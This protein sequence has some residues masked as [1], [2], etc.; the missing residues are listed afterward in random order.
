MSWR[1]LA[2]WLFPTQQPQGTPRAS[3]R[4]LKHQTMHHQKQAREKT[5]KGKNKAT[6]QFFSSISSSFKAMTAGLRAKPEPMVIAMCQ[7]ARSGDLGHL[8]GFVTQ[9]VNINGQNDEGYTPLIC[10]ANAA[11]NK[12]RT[13]LIEALQSEDQTLVQKL[14]TFGADVNKMGQ[15]N[16]L[17]LAR[18]L[19]NQELV[20]MLTERGAQAS[21]PSKVEIAPATP[22]SPN[23]PSTSSR[24]QAL[25]QSGS[26]EMPPPYTEA[27]AFDGL[28]TP[29]TSNSGMKL[30]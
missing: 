21:I 11:D 23:G 28:T 13:P 2:A 6:G 19:Q 25:P 24:R 27:S 3:P 29:G 9:G 12:G 8:K 10:A 30:I 1:N 17:T 5:S 7:A 18:L 26:A 4:M 20:Q 15:I 16:P 14:L 22:V